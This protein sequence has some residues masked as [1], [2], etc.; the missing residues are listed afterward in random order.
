MDTITFRFSISPLFEIT[1]PNDSEYISNETIEQMCL[2]RYDMLLEMVKNEDYEMKKLY[3]GAVTL[4]MID[5]Y[6]VDII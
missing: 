6:V 3:T 4:Q 5:H 1:I 2:D